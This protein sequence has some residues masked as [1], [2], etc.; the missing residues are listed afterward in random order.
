MRVSRWFTGLAAALV[1]MLST[2][3]CA[4]DPGTGSGSASE[5]GGAAGQLTEGP[6]G[7]TETAGTEGGSEPT[8]ASS[9]V[10]LDQVCEQEY[11]DVEADEDF[12]VGLVTDIGSIDDGTFN[13]YAFEGMK[14]AEECFG[15]E[16]NFI[17]TANEADYEN[18]LDT[19]MR[20]EPDV[21]VTVGFLLAD[22]TKKFAE[23][24]D[25]T[26]FVGVDQFQ[27][28]YGDNYSGV[29]FREDQGGYLAGAMAGLL[30]ESNVVGVVGGREDVPPVVRLVNGYE[31]GATAEN[32]DAE[33]LKVYNQS[34]TDDAKGR[35]DAEQM[36]GEGADVI[37]GAGGQTGSGGIKAAAEDGKWAIGVDQDEYFT[38]F[39]EGAAEGS[40]FL[41]T[42]AIKRVD[43]GVFQQIAAAITDE[44]KGGV[45]ILEAANDGITY[46]PFH[47]A[48]IPPD[49]ATRMEEIRQGLA[50]GSIDTGIDP[51]TGEPK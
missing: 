35:S 5:T 22:A 25:D 3:A 24:N 51:V 34:F 39:D 6:T 38:T 26:N 4:N 33:V 40:E 37:F 36:L 43:L 1:L 29:L 8:E 20:D 2:A 10:P 47:E 50:D 9:I 41:A 23:E 19:I 30:T 14:A 32:P 48:D 46:A 44:F 28:D 15:I 31:A 12:K 42:S 49:V 17:E 16:T 7:A 13:Q 18:N 45:F 11:A 27:E 21:V